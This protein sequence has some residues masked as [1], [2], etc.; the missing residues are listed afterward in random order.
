MGWDTVHVECVSQI[1][2]RVFFREAN[3]EED[4]QI[5][6]YPATAFLWRAALCEYREHNTAHRH[7]PVLYR[8]QHSCST[9][10][11]STHQTQKQLTLSCID[12]G[13]SK[14]EETHEDTVHPTHPVLYR[15]QHVCRTRYHAAS[16]FAVVAQNRPRDVCNSILQGGRVH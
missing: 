3:H 13:T 10:A 12:K 9:E 7:N 11:L 5:H 15:R 8:G 2:W 16:A 4:R 1:F 6:D 14:L